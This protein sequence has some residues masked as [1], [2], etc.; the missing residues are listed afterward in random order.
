VNISTADAVDAALL[1]SLHASCF[2]DAWDGYAFAQLLKPENTAAFIAREADMAAGFIML[3]VAAD[4]AEILT[5][6]VVRECRRQ[7]FARKLVL[8]AAE[9]ACRAGARTLFLEVDENNIAARA[10]YDQLGFAKVGRRPGYYRNC[11]SVANALVLK[12][13]LP[14]PAWESH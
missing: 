7:G 14:I 10:L 13:D 3:R 4:E 11:D 5:L 8:L 2:A 1:G 6:A 12:R 9:H